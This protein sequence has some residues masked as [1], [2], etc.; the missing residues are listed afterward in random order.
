[1]K[2]FILAILGIAFLVFP[3][4]KEKTNPS[5]PTIT[6]ANAS[7]SVILYDEGTTP[8]DNSGMQVKIIDSDPELSATTNDEGDWIFEDLEYGTYS[9]AFEKDNY[10]TYKLFD[11]THKN[12]SSFMSTVPSLGEKSTTEVVS[13]TQELFE[14]SIL[15]SAYCTPEANSSNTNYLRFFIGLTDSISYSQYMHYSL[16]HSSNDDPHVFTITQ[17]QLTGYGYDSG[18]TVYIR[19]YGESFWS[20]SYLDPNLG[21]IFP[22][23]N[24]NSVSAISFVVP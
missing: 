3:A 4:C 20:N 8:V 16:V 11:R 9:V 24:P 14:Q 23:L 1:M 13:L 12:G 7:G 15:I 6:S 22:N 21:Q 19:V 17:E 18:T 2:N 10:G 5:P